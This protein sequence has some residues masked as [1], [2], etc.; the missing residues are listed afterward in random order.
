MNRSLKSSKSN[1]EQISAFEA[2]IA[3]EKLEGLADDDG[4]RKFYEGKIHS[5]KHYA[6]IE[7]GKVLSSAKYLGEENASPMEI[8]NDSF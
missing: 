6:G 4:D 8:H 3:E 1:L 2:L 5:A 7:L